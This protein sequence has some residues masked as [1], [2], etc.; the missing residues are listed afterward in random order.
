[1]TA[2]RDL[3]LNG[4]SPRVLGLLS[5]VFSG[6]EAR[7]ILSDR[8]RHPLT[9][10]L[11]SRTL[12]LHPDQAGLYDLAIG[13]E[14]LT[15]HRVLRD[16]PKDPDRRARNLSMQRPRMIRA[17]HDALRNRFSRILSLPGRFRPGQP[18]DGLEIVEKNVEW[19]PLQ[20][21]WSRGFSGQGRSAGI[22][23]D[24]I[25]DLEITGVEGDFQW[26]IDALEAGALPLSTLPNLGELPYVRVP[27][28]ITAEQRFPQMEEWEEQLADPEHQRMLQGFI[29]CHR[30]KSIV[31]EERMHVGRHLRSGTQL[32]PNRLVSA[33][34]GA[35][36]GLEVPVFRQPG[37]I[38]EPVFDPR[39]HLVVATFD[40]NDLRD[41]RWSGNRR[42]ILRFLAVL[43]TCYQR[44]DMDL[45]VQGTADQIVTLSDGRL[46]CVHFVA[47]LKEVEESFDEVFLPRLM[48]WMSRPPGLPGES[49]CFHPLCAEDISKAFDSASRESEHSYH[50]LCWWA[51]RTFPWTCDDL[52]TGPFLERCAEH[53]DHVIHDLGR[54]LEGTFDTSASFLPSELRQFGQ[55]GRY[56]HAVELG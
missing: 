37:S 53:T 52:R 6:V 44:L 46:V 3:T 41:L 11:A 25:P 7:V 54:R 8:A 48:Q 1:M 36:V 50:T 24:V 29:K 9:V 45:V 35:H 56:L 18:R 33:V 13:A 21:H 31:R 26:L 15:N 40:L 32:D 10:A 5:T 17:A 38:I 2:A 43:L 30:D 16:L 23:A 34:I 22:G 51:R 14:L 28:T 27:L 39:E 19:E 4:F 55:P 49:G 42:E 12:V 20:R 47:R